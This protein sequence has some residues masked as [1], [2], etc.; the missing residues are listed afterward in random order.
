MTHVITELV[1]ALAW[2]LAII[3]GAS[4]VYGLVRRGAVQSMSAGKDGVS[5]QLVESRQERE[6]FMN[7]RIAEIDQDLHTEIMAR[8][9]DLKKPLLRVVT[10]AGLCTAALRAI[11]ADLR[12][13]IYQ[14]VDENDFKHKLAAANREGYLKGK[15]A[16]LKDEYDDLVAEVGYDPCAA[17]PAAVIA[18]PPWESVEAGMSRALNGW[19]DKVAEAVSDSCR[20]KVAVYEEYRPQFESAR[21]KKFTKI[22]DECIAKNQGYIQALGRG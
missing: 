20:R 10:G 9:R 13:P 8:T 16:A 12:A 1:K 14:A 2:P 21:D 19:A 5:L 15:L 6:Y 11:A 3:I 4:L 7:R 17:G 22:V 18:F